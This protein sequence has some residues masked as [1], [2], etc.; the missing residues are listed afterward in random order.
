MK[1]NDILK[2]ENAGKIYIITNG[3]WKGEMEELTI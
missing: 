3:E 2:E 1:I